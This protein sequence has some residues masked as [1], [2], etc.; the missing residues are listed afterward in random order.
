VHG[1]K[2]AAWT[3]QANCLPDVPYPPAVVCCGFCPLA[4]HP[5][6]LLPQ[7][8][9]ACGTRDLW[10]GG[11]VRVRGISSTGWE[12]C[13]HAQASEDRLDKAL[14]LTYLTLKFKG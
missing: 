6:S 12:L 3:D 10:A 8:G 11:V 9:T 5:A 7:P 13:F 14:Y 1:P 2:R 4:R